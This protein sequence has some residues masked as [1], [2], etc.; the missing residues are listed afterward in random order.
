MTAKRFILLV[1]LTV[2]A[3][4]TQ[5][6]PLEYTQWVQKAKDFYTAKQ[7]QQSADAFS[8]AFAAFGG[9]RVYGRPVQCRLLMGT[10]RE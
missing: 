1:L 8:R 2:F 4:S 5:A 3:T 6:Q 9:K 10:R 7:Y